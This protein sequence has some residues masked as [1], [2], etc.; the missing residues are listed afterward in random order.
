[1]SLHTRVLTHRHAGNAWH[2]SLAIQRCEQRMSQYWAFA[3]DNTRPIHIFTVSEAW[4]EA[5]MT[6]VLLRVKQK[7]VTK[8]V[9]IA[10]GSRPPSNEA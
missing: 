2:E 9:R 10:F 5:A 4:K 3:S 7:N 6:N 1:M 8:R